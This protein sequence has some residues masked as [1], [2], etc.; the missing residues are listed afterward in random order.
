MN[1]FQEQLKVH[2]IRDAPEWLV[3]K[4]QHDDKVSQFILALLKPLSVP[5]DIRGESHS[6][7]GGEYARG[8]VFC[9]K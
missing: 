1:L 7:G 9:R 2:V 3:L 5:R 6:E 4:L 8:A